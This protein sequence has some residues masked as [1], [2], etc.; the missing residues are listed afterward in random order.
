MGFHR[1]C[2]KQSLRW[3]LHMGR[4]QLV[5]ATL[6]LK[7]EGAQLGHQSWRRVS[8]D[9][10]SGRATLL[11]STAKQV[12]GEK[13]ERPF[14]YGGLQCHFSKVTAEDKITL[15][16]NLDCALSFMSLLCRVFFTLVNYHSLSLQ[17]GMLQGELEPISL[18]YHCMDKTL[19]K[20][21]LGFRS[22]GGYPND[23]ID[24][25]G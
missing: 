16:N 25:K 8:R 7:P 5:E 23:L 3:R 20:K 19:R 12:L 17:S 2:R 21:T 18:M 6:L 10:K 9:G 11:H 24:S 22:R 14:K 4:W 13:S 15:S 1:N